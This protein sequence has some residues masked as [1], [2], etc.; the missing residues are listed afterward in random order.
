MKQILTVLGL[1]IFLNSCNLI[2]KSQIEKM[3][4]MATKIEQLNNDVEEK[5]NAYRQILTEYGLKGDKSLNP[6]EWNML[7]LNDEQRQLLESRL[8]SEKDSSYK[9]LIQE[10][11][12]KDEELKSL[13]NEINDLQQ[14]FPKPVT[15]KQGD[16]HF[17]ICMK[18]LVEQKG[19][20]AKQAQ[21]LVE[22]VN[23]LEYLLPGFDVWLFY[24]NDTFGTFVTK[25]TA[26]MSPNQIKKYYKTKLVND[27]D[28]A[29]EKA[30]KLQED[31]S[32]LENRKKELLSQLQ[33]L[34]KEKE[35]LNMEVASLSNKNTTL[36]KQNKNKEK[37]LNAVYYHADTYAN[38]KNKK[39]IDRVLFGKPQLKQFNSVSFDSVMDLREAD[40]IVISAAQLGLEKIKKVYVMPRH[41]VENKDYKVEITAD[42]Q[43]VVIYIINPAKFQMSKVLIAVK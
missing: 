35:S 29:M 4:K 22:R 24:D 21:K 34:E 5:E 2:E 27:R 32:S 15:V 6:E 42:K 17:D 38:L 16:N 31:V 3:Q 7:A 26:K 25:G 33:E 13:R 12:D 40:S 1:L 36:A 20:E 28:K 37:R 41:F 8:A 43:K 11:L 10:I 23:M 30:Y 9:A 19:L 18:F 14:Q 39:I